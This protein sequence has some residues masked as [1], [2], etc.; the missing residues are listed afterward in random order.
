MLGGLHLHP[1][2]EAGCPG[3]LLDCVCDLGEQSS[4]RCS[5][6]FQC[7]EFD[8]AVHVLSGPCSRFVVRNPRHPLTVTFRW[9]NTTALVAWGL[10]HHQRLP[11]STRRRQEHSTGP[12]AARL[13]AQVVASTPI[14]VSIT[15]KETRPRGGSWSETRSPGI[16][17]VQSIWRK[18][19]KHR[20]VCNTTTKQSGQRHVRK[21]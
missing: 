3:H 13:A 20:R 8:D 17:T 12:W 9:D 16:D 14:S 1:S 10:G 2:I 21:K 7:R 11:V 15:C 5:G 19:V 18:K 4:R 6:L